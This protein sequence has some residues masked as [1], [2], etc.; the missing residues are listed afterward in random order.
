MAIT[1]FQYHINRMG[2]FE[3]GKKSVFKKQNEIIDMCFY[4]QSISSFQQTLRG[5]CHGPHLPQWFWRIFPLEPLDR[6]TD[7]G[8]RRTKSSPGE[9]GRNNESNRDFQQQIQR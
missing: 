7:Q 6:A 4:N 3:D 2:G 1:Y 5:V 8:S 9:M